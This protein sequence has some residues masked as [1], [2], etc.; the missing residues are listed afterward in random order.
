[1]GPSIAF[2]GMTCLNMAQS[3]L[4]A[5]DAWMPNMNP[6][7]L[8]S[9]FTLPKLSSNKGKIKVLTDLMKQSISLNENGGD[10]DLS[11][12]KIVP[13]NF[14]GLQSHFHSYGSLKNGRIAISQ[15]LIFHQNENSN[16]YPD[17]SVTQNCVGV[18]KK[19]EKL[20]NE[21]PYAPN[22]I[23]SYLEEIP[24]SDLEDY[25]KHLEF[26][27]LDLNFDELR[28]ILSHEIGHIV[29]HDPKHMFTNSSIFRFSGMLI[30][31]LF[32]ITYFPSQALPLYL[33]HLAFYLL[34]RL[35]VTGV[36]RRKQ[37]RQA[38]KFAIEQGNEEGGV[39]VFKR[40]LILDWLVKKR[41]VELSGKQGKAFSWV[42]PLR[43]FSEIEKRFSHPS[44]MQRL[45]SCAE[46]F[47]SKLI[48]EA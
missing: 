3:A 21:F 19:F 2:C 34:S 16:I 31:E 17:S 39:R 11:K 40:L 9:K 7:L 41:K 25:L 29:K 15:S 36:I 47:Q 28:F 44:L 8:Y 24:Q 33:S 12:V 37:E 48:G 10:I 42:S 4:E 35:A 23:S 26:L 14:D 22:A 32:A 38:D 30:A 27:S 20:L 18:K 46:C 43:V 13:K 6:S 5:V 1:M 45:K